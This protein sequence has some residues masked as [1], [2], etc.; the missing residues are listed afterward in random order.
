M[1]MKPLST[2]P[3]PSISEYWDRYE[4]MPYW[5]VYYGRNQSA[6]FPARVYGAA[7]AERIAN[8]FV[9]Q[10]RSGVDWTT[11]YGLLPKE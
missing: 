8:D 9:R 4:Q 5:A 11:A 3:Q 6:Y 7:R 10:L 2:R 1:K